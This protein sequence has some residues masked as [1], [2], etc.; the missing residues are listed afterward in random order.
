MAAKKLSEHQK[1]KAKEIISS[2]FLFGGDAEIAVIQIFEATSI[3]VSTRQVYH[4]LEQIKAKSQQKTEQNLEQVRQGELE[5]LKYLELETIA[6]WQRSKQNAETLTTESVG[7]DEK[8]IAE[9]S[10]ELTDERVNRF[11]GDPRN[12][13]PELKDLKVEVK[14]KEKKQ[15]SGR[16]GEP[17]YIDLLIKIQQRRADLLGLDAPSKKEISINHPKP[18]KDMTNAEL[19]KYISD[20]ESS[21]YT[22]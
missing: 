6:Q 11:D 19:S 9:F 17:K 20:L 21:V 2:V 1:V 12:P 22:N 18:I 16:T 15:V 5:K 14:T 4:Y 7:V 3:K 10:K 8:E 13:D